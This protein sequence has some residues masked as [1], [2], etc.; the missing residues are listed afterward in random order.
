MYCQPL[1]AN[2]IPT[3][4]QPQSENERQQSVND[5]LCCILYNPRAVLRHLLIIEVLA[6]FTVSIVIVNATTPQLSMEP[7]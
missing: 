5:F 4:L 2:A 7:P 1:C 3:W 6:D